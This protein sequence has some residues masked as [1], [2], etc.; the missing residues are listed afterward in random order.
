MDR[1]FRFFPAFKLITAIAGMVVISVRVSA[2][3]QDEIR[4]AGPQS[5]VES[6]EPVRV[7]DNSANLKPQSLRRNP[8]QDETSS[9]KVAQQGGPQVMEHGAFQKQP[10]TQIPHYPAPSFQPAPAAS[11]EL[12]DLLFQPKPASHPQIDRGKPQPHHDQISGHSAPTAVKPVSFHKQAPSIGTQIEMPAYI[13]LNQTARMR[14]K[15]QNH[16]DVSATRVKLLATVPAHAQFVSSNPAPTNQSGSILEFQIS[17]IGPRQIQEVVINLVPTEKKALEI[18]TEVLIENVQRFSVGV[19]EPIIKMGLQGPSDA[20]LGEAILHQVVLENVG[21]GMAE[22][23]QLRAD[24]PNQL[25]CK[26]KNLVVIPS[27]APGQRIEVEIPSIA[28]EAGK[29]ELAVTMGAEGVKSQTVKAGIQVFQPE[30]E[31]SA[32]GPQINFLNREGIYSIVLDNTGLVDAT[33]VTVDLLVAPG[34]KV[35]TISH[36]AKLDP[37]TGRLTW[38]VDKIAANSMHTIKLLTLTTQQ[39][40]QDCLFTVKSQQTKEK[41]IQLTTNV[42]TR[43]ELAIK[44]QNQSGPVAVGG[45]VQFL[46]IVENTGSSCAENIAIKVEFPET[47]AVDQQDQMEVLGIGNQISFDAAK[48]EPG[49]KREFRFVAV[50]NEKGEHVVRTILT[51]SESQRHLVSEG[52]VYVYE[53]N[54]NRVSELLSPAV[55]R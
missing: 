52:G 26:N 24:F 14:I 51:T 55:I 6:R 9:S 19:R 15:L 47:L 50:A 54:E 23:L 35:T 17:E 3:A 22:Q 44:L 36:P 12:D 53:V 31:V 25:R 49:Q 38:K 1:V 8:R 13:N 37:Q 45:K 20:N 32:T 11:E 41:T 40:L 34:M 29:S 16:S 7:A 27:L 39:G 43:P 46:V 4:L 30:L 42:V 33:E 5:V 10:A 21:D 28:A 2:Q 48:L 18:G